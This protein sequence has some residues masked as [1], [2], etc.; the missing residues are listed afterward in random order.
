M[1]LQRR[2]NFNIQNEKL[3]KEKTVKFCCITIVIFFLSQVAL[4]EWKEQ[5]QTREDFLTHI[6]EKELLQINTKNRNMGKRPL[7]F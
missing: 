6:F 2:E 4:Q 7:I 5:L 3:I 1:Y